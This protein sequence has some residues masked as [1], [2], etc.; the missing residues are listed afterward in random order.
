VHFGVLGLGSK[1]TLRFS[2]FEDCYE[3]LSRTE[4][5]YRKVK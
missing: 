1:E 5:L 3:Q 4:K 2:R